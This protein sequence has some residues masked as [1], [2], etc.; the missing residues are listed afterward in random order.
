M[1][2]VRK[3]VRQRIS[4]RPV[5]VASVILAVILYLITVTVGEEAA[6]A[7]EPLV[8]L[9]LPLLAGW[10][11]ERFTFSQ[12]FMR[13]VLDILPDEFGGVI[14]EQDTRLS[15]GTNALTPRDR[16]A[17]AVEVVLIIVAVV[18]IL[19]LLGFVGRR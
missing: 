6:T 10:V 1:T 18:L 15:T 8:L 7:A 17:T 5:R 9:A 12:A 14:R 19:F 2:K 16:G 4:E 13:R 11:T 3:P